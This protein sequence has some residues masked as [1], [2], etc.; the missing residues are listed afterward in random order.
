M[1]EQTNVK[2][3]EVRAH[4]KSYLE[5]WKKADHS[6]M[7]KLTTATYRKRY[8]GKSMLQEKFPDRLKSY[9]IK[10]VVEANPVMYDVFFHAVL[11]GKRHLL[12]VRLVQEVDAYVPSNAGDWGVNPISIRD[13]VAKTETASAE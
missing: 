2:E 3:P 6:K 7:Q 4:L 12:Y 5:A 1:S 8:P 11:K 9:S 10:K 13:V